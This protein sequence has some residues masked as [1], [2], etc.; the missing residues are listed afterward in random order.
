MS[1]SPP[2]VAHDSPYLMLVT[3]GAPLV[4]AWGDEHFAVLDESPYHGVAVP[5][6]DAYDTAPVP[7]E[8]AFADAVA[9]IGRS[10][11]KHMWPWVFSNR[12]VAQS[13]E[14]AREPGQSAEYFGR[15]RGWDLGDE[16]G[17]LSDFLAI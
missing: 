12:F 17:A 3:F 10:T 5:V 16:T 15:I 2:A 14:C 13:M 6:L 7:P 9:T 11:R 4:N 1:A 8:D